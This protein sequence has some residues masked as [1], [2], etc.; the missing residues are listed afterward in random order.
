M[1]SKMRSVD[2]PDFLAATRDG[3]DRIAAIYAER[4]HHHLDDTPVDL[5]V[6]SAFAGLVLRGPNRKVIDIGCGTGAITARLAGCG[7]DVTGVDLSPN[8]V[9]QAHRLN[10]G[11]SFSV[12]SMANL[13]L[14]DGSVGGIC[15]WYSIIHTPDQ[16]LAGVFD[17]FHR[18]LAPGGLAL[19]A[20]QVGGEPR[21]LT[22]V[23]GQ[24]VNLTFIRRQPQWVSKQLAT[25][26]LNVYV[27]LLREPD[28]D[29]LEST[30]QAYLIARKSVRCSAGVQRRSVSEHTSAN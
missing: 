22:E 19:L 10:P 5:A 21:V 1:G 16:Y 15:A 28:D 12:G 20:F 25:A 8:M 2:P 4:L 17:E 6:I 11:L 27:E 3:Y 30:P 26:G 9:A 23:S 14:A 18:V 24:Q 29:D 13:G 7:V